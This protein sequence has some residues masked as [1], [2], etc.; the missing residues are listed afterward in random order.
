MNFAAAFSGHTFTLKTKLIG[1]VFLKMEN[2]EMHAIPEKLASI[3]AYRAFPVGI[4]WN[5][6]QKAF[7]VED[8]L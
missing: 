4:R 7:I 1:D 6:L 8:L 2:L 3:V 5:I